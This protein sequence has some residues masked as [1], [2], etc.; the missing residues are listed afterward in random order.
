MAGGIAS[1]PVLGSRSTHVASGIGG[2]D[3]GPLKAGDELPVGP[4]PDVRDHLR[5]PMDLV[6]GI[7]S[8]ITVRVVPGPQEDAFTAAG[9]GTFYGSGYAISDRS[10][11]QGVRLEGPEIGAVNERYD[12]VSDAVV[13]WFDTGAGRPEADNSAGRPPNYGRVPKDR[14]CRERPISQSSPRPSRRD[15]QVRKN[16]SGGRR[17]PRPGNTGGG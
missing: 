6:P 14:N 7:E 3:G 13:F 4:A 9:V 12:I 16:R 5:V 1:A 17:R 15:Y 10:D 8:S 2:I 11:R